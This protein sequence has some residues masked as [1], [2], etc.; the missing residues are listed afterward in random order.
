M[1]SGA[2]NRSTTVTGTTN[3]YF[4]SG[5]WTLASGRFF[6]DSE[7][8]GA[9][10][11]RP[12]RDHAQRAAS[13]RRIPSAIGIRAAVA[14]SCTVIGVLESKGQSTFGHDQDDIVVM[15]LRTLQRR[16]AGN[17]DIQ[18]IQL[19]V[20][21][22]RRRR[23]RAQQD[24]FA[25]DAGAPPPRPRCRGRLHVLRPRR[26]SPTRSPGTT[27]TLTAL[28][29]A[30]AAVSLLVGGI[31]IMN[32]MLVSVT[33]R[34][35][36][37]GIRLAIGALERDVL[38]QFLVEAVVLSVFGGA[39]GIGLALRRRRSRRARWACLSCSTSA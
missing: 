15:P 4:E 2:K 39:L 7:L 38:M 17:D 24:I 12:R 9:A 20:A 10:G 19:S 34:T 8:R 16:L 36:E 25:L 30:V 14:S 26:S 21:R 33:E 6:S 13:A 28:L 35:R 37:I 11:L 18:Q 5:N 31:G 1:I 27:R 32:I 29:G 22:R 3:A 23:E